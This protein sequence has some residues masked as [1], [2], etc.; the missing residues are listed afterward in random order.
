MAHWYYRL[1]IKDVWQ[2]EALPVTEKAAAIAARIRTK[3]K[4]GMPYV[5]EEIFEIA[6]AF[7]NVTTITDL[8]PDDLIEEFD[9]AMMQL[10]DWGDAEWGEPG[11]WPPRR[12]CWV[13]TR[14]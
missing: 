14:L 4:E 7:H 5:D 12:L 13:A 11:H 8:D 3:F 2:N 6:D 9:N 1:D 10:Y